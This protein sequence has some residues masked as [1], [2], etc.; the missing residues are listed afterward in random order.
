[1]K[2]LT[3][4][5]DFN[6]FDRIFFTRSEWALG[7]YISDELEIKHLNKPSFESYDVTDCKARGVADPFLIEYNGDVYIFFEIEKYIDS[8]KTK[9]VIGCAK[10]VANKIKYLGIVLEE[11]FHL[12]FPFL[13]KHDNDIFMMPESS[14]SNKLYLYKCI[15]FPF[16]WEKYKLLLDGHFLDSTLFYSNNKWNLLTLK[17]YKNT[18]LYIADSLEDNFVFYKTL[19]TNNK[20][21]GRNGGFIKDFRI[22]QDCSTA[23]GDRVHFFKYNDFCEEYIATFNRA[24]GYKWDSLNLHHFNFIEA[25]GQSYHIYDAKG[26]QLRIRRFFKRVFS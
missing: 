3:R 1:M 17:D 5:R 9:G 13:L 4:N 11:D 21:I 8:K 25:K 26:Y 22:A 14:A 6:S 19:Y 24:C 2:L 18:N 16:K 12:S 23:Y 10:I 20:A 15:D 7:F